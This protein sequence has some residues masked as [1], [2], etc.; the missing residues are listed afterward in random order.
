MFNINRRVPW[1]PHDLA[2]HVRNVVN[3]LGGT[4]GWAHAHY[5]TQ[6]AILDAGTRESLQGV[7]AKFTRRHIR[8]K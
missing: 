1:V 4:G 6:E 8:E 3:L 7:T 2:L 5:C